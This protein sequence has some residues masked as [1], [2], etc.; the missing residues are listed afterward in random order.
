M[1]RGRVR[2]LAWLAG[3]DGAR[4]LGACSAHS[5]G[6]GGS[7]GSNLGGRRPT[8]PDAANCCPCERHHGRGRATRLAWLTGGAGARDLDACS[9]HAARPGGNAGS[10]PGATRPISPD[11]S[12][13]SP[14][15][16]P[17]VGRTHPSGTRRRSPYR[18][19]TDDPAVN[20]GRVAAFGLALKTSVFRF[21]RK[22]L[23][24]LLVTCGDCREGEDK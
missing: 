4:D 20:R 21:L 7:G 13:R 19:R 15:S 17:A 11:A 6:A 16:R 18:T 23:T 24:A 3:G 9:A 2:R 1:G 12:T 8:G 14:Y 10:T 5:A 22:R